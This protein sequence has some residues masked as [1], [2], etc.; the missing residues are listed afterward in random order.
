MSE[1]AAKSR[2]CGTESVSLKHKKTS[3][4]PRGG[5]PLLRFLCP[6]KGNEGRGRGQAKPQLFYK[7]ICPGKNTHCMHK[8]T[9]PLLKQSVRREIIK[10]SWYNNIMK[11]DRNKT[12]LGKAAKNDDGFVRMSPAERISFMWELTAE[13]WSLRKSPYVK[14]RLQRNITNLIKQ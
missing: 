14:R 10:K 4:V 1:W 11:V 13:V 8:R 6:H 3:A 5:F 2:S 7:K 12:Y 9:N